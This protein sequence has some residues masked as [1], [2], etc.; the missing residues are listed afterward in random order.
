ML[1]GWGESTHHAKGGVPTMLRGWVGG[2]GGISIM[3]REEGLDY[4]TRHMCCR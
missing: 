4:L 1:R 3:L 2:G